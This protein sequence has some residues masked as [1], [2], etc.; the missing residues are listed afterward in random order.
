MFLKLFYFLFSFLILL[1]AS[2]YA[3]YKIIFILSLSCMFLII[4]SLIFSQVRFGI[5]N[6]FLFGFGYF[7]FLYPLIYSL[8]LTEIPGIAYKTH[9]N[10]TVISTIALIVYF[11]SYNLKLIA[12]NEKKFYLLD[13]ETKNIFKRKYYFIILIF[14]S[15]F[16]LRTLPPLVFNNYLILYISLLFLILCLPKKNNFLAFLVFISFFILM[17][18]E[19]SGR[20]DLIKI[21][22]IFL[23]FLQI[24]N[25]NLSLFTLAIFFSST[26]LGLILITTLRSFSINWSYDYNISLKDIIENPTYLKRTLEGYGDYLQNALV[27]GDFGA[28]YNNYMY[29][30]QNIS[31]IGYLYG[32]SIFR[33]FYTWIPRSFWE[34]KPYDVQL[35]IV[36]FN[37]DPYYTGGSSQS[38]TFIGELFWNYGYLAIILMLFFIGQI[39]RLIDKNLNNLKNYQVLALLTLAPFFML[40]WRG[41][42]STTLVYAVANLMIIYFCYLISNIRIARNINY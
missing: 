16:L 19:S 38:I 39:T 9:L 42:F 4:F 3:N 36:K 21:G 29:I 34:G 26:I 13:K 5:N 2:T 8:G 15:F 31:E 14:L 17:V 24:N 37:I 12:V 18:L 10:T 40:L 6:I 25:G 11:L 28:A 32:Q 41:A 35:L 33:I 30:Y 7:M 27:L 22:I 20:R 23:L 1:V